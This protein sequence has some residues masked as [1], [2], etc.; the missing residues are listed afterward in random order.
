M[1]HSRPLQG[2]NKKVLSTAYPQACTAP[3]GLLKR[4]ESGLSADD[5]NRWGAQS[6]VLKIEVGGH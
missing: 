1:L 3:L 6:R 2:A 5:C 4:S